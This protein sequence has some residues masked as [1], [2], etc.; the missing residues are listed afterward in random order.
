[1][2]LGFRV[3]A[4]LP[5]GPQWGGR[6]SPE[7]FIQ[8]LI[9]RIPERL[10]DSD[11]ASLVGWGSVPNGA[12]L[13]LHP[14]E[15]PFELRLEGN[16]LFAQGKTSSAGPGYHAFLIEWLER[17]GSEEGF[18][19]IWSDPAREVEDET[20][21]A[22]DRDFA[23]L[24]GEMARWFAQVAE[25]LLSVEADPETVFALAMPVGFAWAGDAFALSSL[26]TWSREFIE[27]AADGSA[28]SGS[29]ASQYFPWWSKDRDADF[30]RNCGLV[31]AWTDV[32]W[33]EPQGDEERRFF[34]VT[35]RCW[36]RAR[37]LD[38]TVELPEAEWAEL[39]ACL[40]EDPPSRPEPTGIGFRR[41][42]LTKPLTGGW[43]IDV[44]G[45]FLESTEKEGTTI[46]FWDRTRTIRATSFSTAGEE[47]PPVPDGEVTLREETREGSAEIVAVA[48]ESESYWQ[49]QGEMRSASSLCV[50]T[51]AYEDEASRAWAIETW[52]SLRHR[53]G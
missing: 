15:E 2:G 41:G 45:W 43:G 40:S 36:S 18:S 8:N 13:L 33:R 49:L 53:E 47:L 25:H 5:D 29:A 24:Q 46:L 19:W 1:M 39:R 30:W 23:K 17:I 35:D 4:D 51:I 7:L 48:S 26:G 20:G 3:V 22:I 27:E 52:Q 6:G 37:T 31:Y 34:E 11:H 28:A 32:P 42:R 10:G 44:P 21:Y 38:P 14:A 50:I 9:D 16:Q 12:D